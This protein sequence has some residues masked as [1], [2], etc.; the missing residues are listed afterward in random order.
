MP[1][2]RLFGPFRTHFRH[3]VLSRDVGTPAREKCAVGSPGRLLKSDYWTIV[4]FYENVG[5]AQE[6][7]VSPMALPV[8]GERGLNAAQSRGDPA[9]TMI[10]RIRARAKMKYLRREAVL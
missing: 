8:R 9:G 3:A 4:H 2:W 1:Q 10:M 5:L 7:A 6:I